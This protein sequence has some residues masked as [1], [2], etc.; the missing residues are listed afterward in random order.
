MG[1]ALLAT[2]V[3]AAPL[4]RLRDPFV[5]VLVLPPLAA[6]LDALG[7]SRV[8][9]DGLRRIRS[10][11]AR[12]LGAYLVWLA[13]SALLTLDVAAVA[14]A[15]VGLAVGGRRSAERDVQLGAAIVG[16]NVG[17]LLFPFSNLTN[18]V[19]LV[20]AG[21]SFRAYVEA[22]FWPQLAT[23]LGAGAVLLWRSRR[24]L[25]AEVPIPDAAA[26][27]S[28]DAADPGSGA[29][30]RTAWL[31]GGIVFVGAVVAVLAGFRG[32]DLAAVFALTAALV[33]AL[34]A[35]SGEST[36]RAL[37]HSIPVAGVAVILGAALLGGPMATLAAHLPVP[38]RAAPGLPA[39]VGVALVGGL[40]AALANNLPAAAF[41]AVWLAGARPDLVVAY[42][43]GTNV[44]A[45][46]T[47]H[48][49]LATL[50]CRAVAARGGHD[51]PHG[52]YLRAAWRFALVGGAAALAAL[53]LLG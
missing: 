47:P 53:V 7:W 9:A 50:L 39:L 1:L 25:A 17:S 6:A 34:A 19:L 52:P 42:L 12:A 29:L 48:G 4:G 24:R 40:L 32:G 44:L 8:A 16:S 31:A 41:G 35:G 38:A 27:G 45:L 21:I 2:P 18:L 14:A 46:L 43:V 3:V 10:P 36:P 28:V 22:A 30:S 23:A 37:G 13:T 15:S 5:L 33:S 26:A 11:L 51:L 20:G 49:S